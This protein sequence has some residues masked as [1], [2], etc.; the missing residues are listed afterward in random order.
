MVFDGLKELKMKLEKFSKI[1]VIGDRYED[2]GLAKNL[3][4]NYIDVKG[5][6]YDDLLLEYKK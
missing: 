5:K 2:E 4:A 6:S 1:I 3:N